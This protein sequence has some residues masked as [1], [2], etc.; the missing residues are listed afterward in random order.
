MNIFSRI[1]GTLTIYALKVDKTDIN[2]IMIYILAVLNL[3]IADC[4][5]WRILLIP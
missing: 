4:C 1:N 2:Y 5:C 3:Y